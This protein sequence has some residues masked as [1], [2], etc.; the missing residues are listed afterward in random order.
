MAWMERVTPKVV[1]LLYVR[2]SPW[3]RGICLEHGAFIYAK[4][5][6]VARRHIDNRLIDLLQILRRYAPPRE[7]FAKLVYSAF[8]DRQLHR[9]LTFRK[10]RHAY[11]FRARRLTCA[12]RQLLSRQWIISIRVII[13]VR[14]SS[15]ESHDALIDLRNRR[16][17]VHIESAKADQ[18]LELSR[19]S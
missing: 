16:F 3:T 14:S 17:D 5:S 4:S 19:V 7:H 12:Y 15:D 10:S 2:D 11:R 6:A 18:I 9:Y 1:H 13:R 8:A